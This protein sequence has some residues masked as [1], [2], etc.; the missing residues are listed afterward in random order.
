M[1]CSGQGWQPA[2]E[3][4]RRP[5][6]RELHGQVGRTIS[7]LSTL[8][9]HYVLYIYDIY[10]L[11]GVA[12]VSVGAIKASECWAIPGPGSG[13]RQ[14]GPSIGYFRNSKYSPLPVIES[15]SSSNMS[16]CAHWSLADSFSLVEHPGTRM[17]FH[18]KIFDI[19][20]FRWIVKHKQSPTWWHDDFYILSFTTNN[21]YIVEHGVRRYFCMYVDRWDT[22]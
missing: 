5:G 11:Y 16:T 19:P 9:L 7:T 10:S 17:T 15:A 18:L 13:Y 4:L 20:L 8:Y 3:L 2:A 1:L 6:E 22:G 21:R 14:Q 12:S